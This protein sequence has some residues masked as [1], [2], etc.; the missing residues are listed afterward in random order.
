MDIDYKVCE[1]YTASRTDAVIKNP[2]AEQRYK[3][4]GCYTCFGFNHHCQ[5]Y[6]NSQFIN[7]ER[8][9]VCEK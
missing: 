3:E 8:M 6:M 7:K 9:P 5:L 2:E 4:L 1:Y